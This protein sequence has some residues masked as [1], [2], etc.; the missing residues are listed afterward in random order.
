MLEPSLFPRIKM[1][2]RFFKSIFS[3]ETDISVAQYIIELTCKNKA[4]YLNIVLPP[5]FWDLPEWSIFYKSQLRKCYYYL[6]KYSE[7]AIINTIVNKNIFS[8]SAK[9]I[10]KEFEKEEKKLNNRLKKSK[11]TENYDRIYNSKGF[12]NK[13]DFNYLD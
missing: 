2:T 1:S 10:D 9:W 4:N 12:Q 3:P 7:E 11:D 8:L 6:T 5:K 13:K